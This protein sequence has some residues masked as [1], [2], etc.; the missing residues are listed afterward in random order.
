M[1]TIWGFIFILFLAEEA[2]SRLVGPEQHN[3]KIQNGLFVIKNNPTFLLGISYFDA[4]SAPNHILQS[5]ISFLKSRKF[6]AIRVWGT[7]HEEFQPSV[8]SLIRNN[9]TLNPEGI[10]RLK[11]VLNV[12]RTNGF[13]VKL[14]FSRAAVG[15]IGIENY[16]RAIR[17][18]TV[19]LKPYRGVMFDVQNETNNCGG[20]RDPDC[21]G[22]L[23]LARIA[24]IRRA[25]KEV[26]PNRLVTASRNGEPVTHGKDDYRS[27][28]NIADVDFI[29]TH[30]PSR[31]RDGLWAHYTDNEAAE[32]RSILGPSVPILFDEPN[33]CGGHMNCTAQSE[34]NLFITA[35]RN[36]KRSG[37]AGWFFHTQA[38]FRLTS[39][40]LSSQLNP[41]ERSAV[42]R[43]ASAVGF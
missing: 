22:H 42:D 18:L 31:T 38:G 20:L 39:R 9:G 30:R 13:A 6:N 33:R 23:S 10:T 14:V 1:K 43:L 28:K 36:A 5:D 16:K 19:I 37:S 27:F 4:L 35:A 26:D 3:L 12:A 25:I 40:T 11:H 34:S 7:W 15:E 17:N 8:I 24:D 32:I 21:H 29:A 41:I 2:N